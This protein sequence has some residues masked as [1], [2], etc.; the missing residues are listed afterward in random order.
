[1]GK[2]LLHND[3]Q[4]LANIMCLLFSVDAGSVQQVFRAFSMKRAA[5]NYSISA[6]RVN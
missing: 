5:I 1:M 4:L 2:Y 6:V 3:H